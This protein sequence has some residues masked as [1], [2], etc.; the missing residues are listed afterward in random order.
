[1]LRQLNIPLEELALDER[2]VSERI[3]RVTTR[4]H[5]RIA[6]AGRAGDRLLVFCESAQ[7]AAGRCRI[8]QFDGM[9]AEDLL[10]EVRGRYDADFS[11]A[12]VWEYA[13][14]MWG[15]FIQPTPERK[16]AHS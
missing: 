15:M 13:G 5:L 8:A 14:R 4:Q 16:E 2:A 6:G 11:T 10:A 7:D 1:M 9:S 12:A 3:N